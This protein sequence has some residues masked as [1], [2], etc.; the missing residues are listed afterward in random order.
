MCTNL[1]Y[2][3][4]QE[5]TFFALNIEILSVEY[6]IHKKCCQLLIIICISLKIYSITIAV[7]Q[8]WLKSTHVKLI[9]TLKYGWHPFTMQCF[10][11]FLGIICVQPWSES[12]DQL[13]PYFPSII[14]VQPWSECDQLYP[15][16]PGIVCVQPW[17]K[18]CDQ[19]YPYFPGIICI[20]PWSESCDQVYPYFPGIICF[21]PWSES[22]DQL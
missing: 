22:C 10:L 9:P 16:F 2:Q 4:F 6:N 3:K 18:S 11:V 15:Y 7:K 17:C 13:Y 5:K 19:L 12:C 8:C 14:C 20:Q 21:Q 1:I